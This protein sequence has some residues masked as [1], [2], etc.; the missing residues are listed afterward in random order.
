M[1]IFKPVI[2]Q[3]YSKNGIVSHSGLE[4][5]SELVQ[6]GNDILEKV[7]PRTEVIGI[8]EAQFLGESVVEACTKLAD[9]GQ[10]RDRRRPRHRF[11]GPPV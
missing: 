7:A 5:A 3:R 6:T 4:I 1:Q 2:D 9:L 8:D 10:A 11:H